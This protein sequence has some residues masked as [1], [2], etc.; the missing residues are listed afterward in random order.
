M[1]SVK[2][3]ILL[4]DYHRHPKYQRNTAGRYRVGAK[5]PKEAVQLLREKIGFGCIQVYYECEPGDRNNVNY[6]EVVKERFDFEGKKLT[7]APPR[8]ATAPQKK[9]Q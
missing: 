9:L 5:T 2:N 3:Y 4:V 1:K 8:H 7:F 6:K